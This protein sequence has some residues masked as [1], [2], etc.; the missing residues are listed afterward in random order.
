MHKQFP[1]TKRNGAMLIYKL[2][3]WY[4]HITIYLQE[5]GGVDSCTQCQHSRTGVRDDTAIHA[6]DQQADPTANKS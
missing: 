1:V 6:R 2:K 4:S 3:E 5:E